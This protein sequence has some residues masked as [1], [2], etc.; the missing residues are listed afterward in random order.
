MARKRLLLINPTYGVSFWGFEHSVALA[1]RSYPIA[2]LSL[3][4]VAALTPDDWD[5]HIVDENVELLD[6]D[7]PADVVGIT[8]M[9]VQ[10]ARAFAMADAF[11][12]RGR[13]VV[14]G[15]PF[16]TL[17]PERCRPH[18]DVLVVG[19]A[20]L[21]WPQFCRD[22]SRGEHKAE[23]AQHDPV[24]VTESPVPRYDLLRAGAYAAM[25]VQTTRGCPFSCEFC[26]IIVMQGRRVRAKRPNQVVR[27]LMRARAAGAEVIFFS[28][29]NFIGNQRHAKAVLAAVIEMRERTGNRPML[30][31]QASVNLADKP[32]LLAQMVRAGF[33]RVFL[34]IESPRQ[35]S[36]RE[37]GKRQNTHGDLIDRIHTIQR[38]GLMVWAG[39]I[40]GFDH[41]DERIFEEQAAFLDEAGIAVAMVGMLNAPPRT[42]LYTRLARA[43]RLDVGSD[44]A[45]N[46]AWTNIVPLSMSRA[47]LFDGYATLLRGLYTQEAYTRRLFSNVYRM[48]PAEAGD[49]GARTPSLDELRCLARATAAFTLSKDAVRRRHFLPNLFRV[50]LRSP[51]RVTETAI[52]LALWQHY[53]RYVPDLADRL[54]H[55]AGAERVRRRETDWAQRPGALAAG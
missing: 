50:G 29:D 10:S 20:E 15:G 48:G 49:T 7:E 34:G 55:A 21:T 19:E 46:C 54:E 3:A 45:D 23:Y 11:R 2:P 5:I 38:A 43:G 47:A 40:V 25:P 12:S 36:L 53:D 16:A 30:Y 13:V 51:S 37:A 22:F 39:M 24:D 18:A 42:P 8:A 1:G 4:T 9:N 41:D 28:D 17:Q 32:K 31:T 27:E 35:S 26:D 44:W 52:H 6:L 33:T 14:L